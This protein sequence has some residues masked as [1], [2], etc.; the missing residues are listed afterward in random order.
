MKD[1]L[2]TAKSYLPPDKVELI[3]QAYRF[4]QSAHQGQTR[5]SGEPYV[6]HPVHVALFLAD[7][8]L[9]TATLVAAL[10][11][12]V[13]EDCSVSYGEMEQRF[14]VEV[15]QLVDGVT[16]L[17]KMDLMVAGDG[18]RHGYEDGQAESLR[19]MLVAMAQDI[20][21]V[22][23][24]LADRL[25]NMQTLQAHTPE[26]RAAIARETLEIYAPLA[27]R[28]GIGDIKWRLE[29]L[30]FSYLQPT[31]YRKVSLLL[32]T[33]RE[34]R[35]EYV[36]RICEVLR[37][38]LTR[39]GVKAEVT[40]RAKHIYSIYQKMEKYAQQGKEFGQIYDLFALR[41]LV[42][43]IQDCYSA[44]GVIHSLWHPIPG[45]FDD[46]IAS[47][48]EN[49]YQSLHTSVMY[50]PNIPLEVQIRT[51]DMHQVSE[52]GV[53][54][55]WRYKE[56]DTKDPHFEEKMSWLRQLLDWQREVTGAAEFLDS[57]KMDI[58]QDQ[59]FVYTPKGEIKELPAGSTPIDFAYRIHTDLG[60][61]C[62]GGK[63]NGRLVPLYTQLKNGDTVEILITKVARGPSL[64]WLN[65]NL[66]YVNTANAREKIRQWFRKQ[67]RGVNIQRGRELLNKELRRLSL[68]MNEE[69][70]A[71]LLKFDSGAELLASLG[72]GS[73]SIA[74]VTAKLAAQQEPPPME[75]T[76]SLPLSWP[77]SGIE[78]LG[79]GD[80]LTR[81]SQCCN[82]I[83]GDAIV[84][85]ITRGRGV[86]IHRVDCRNIQ[87]EDEKER[88]VQVNWGKTQTLH[89][90]RLH[91]EAWDRVGLLRD[92][93]TLVSQDKVNIAS[94]V[95]T[96]HEDSICSVYLT[97]YTTGVGQLSRLFSRLEGVEGVFS[98]ARST[99][100]EE[101]QV[102]SKSRA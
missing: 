1:L 12:D 84:G 5:L 48:K 44:L 32:A 33:K 52:Y 75:H 23:I 98:V 40:G 67:E 36:D 65:T 82:P 55:H 43:E 13:M 37:E 94:L 97:L 34:E 17:S 7:L 90:V 49:M 96:E 39:A 85:Y 14:G 77:S 19:K 27:H 61:R 70:V 46:Y 88:L 74:L 4:A 79:V 3:D 63:V 76:P 38:E 28:L 9:D 47:P 87:N 2:T 95:S 51:Y 45:E 35:E 29:D 66:G 64:D 53:A 26:K 42:D 16:K 15:V 92:I 83:P 31:E 20:R 59:V 68:K 41:I 57:V 78:V 22:L 101:A 30:A 91:I 86:S 11:H 8:H 25:H 100:E 56:G 54:A 81:I 60:H 18:I 71:T 6:E 102:S 50:L 10:L 73:V 72:S 99:P 62:I 21:V 58:F 89:P 24:K 93:T 69:E 80:L